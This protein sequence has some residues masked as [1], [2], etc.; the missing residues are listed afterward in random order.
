MASSIPI[1]QVVK[2][3]PSALAAAGG[4]AFINGLILTQSSSVVSTG[5]ISAYYSATDV[6]TAFGSSSLES[7]M[8]AI[9]FAGFT[10]SDQTPNVL[11]FGGVADP[12]TGGNSYSAQLETLYG[13]SQEWAGLSS[14]FEPTLAEKQDIATWIG[15][16]SD[17]FWYVPYDTDTQATTS[18]S[19]TAFGVWLANQNIDGTTPVYSDPLLAAACL[20]WMASLDYDMVDGRFNLFGRRFSGLTASVS[21]GTT[22]EVLTANGYTFYGLHGNGLGRFTFVRNGAVSGQFLWADSYINQIWLNASFQYDLLSMLLENGNIPYNTQGDAIISASLQDTI[23]QAISFGAIRTG[24]TLTEEQQLEIK[25]A[26][27]VSTAAQSVATNG[28][29][30]YTD[31]AGTPSATRVTRGSPACKFWYTDGQSIQSINLAS[32]EVQ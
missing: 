29:Y 8:A 11:Y 2:V 28:Y 30:L 17:R 1:S 6:S 27:G 3:T 18:N 9:Y 4:V 19:T 21:D 25:N 31:A 13:V 7:E 5:A 10:G 22:A 14:A 15:Q 32:I 24:V 12:S 20:G 16:Q 23:N 26:T